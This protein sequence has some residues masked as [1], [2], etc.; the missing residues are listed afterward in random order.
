MND[1]FCLDNKR[2]F[3]TTKVI[4]S[5]RSTKI[6]TLKV[7]FFLKSTDFCHTVHLNLL[8]NMKYL[9]LWNFLISSCSA[10]CA[11]NLLV[12]FDRQQRFEPTGEIIMQFG[13][14]VPSVFQDVN[15]YYQ[16]FELTTNSTQSQYKY[17]KQMMK[18]SCKEPV[19]PITI[20]SPTIYVDFTQNYLYHTYESI[21]DFNGVG[22]DTL[23]ILQDWRMEEGEKIIQGYACKKA[24][25][26]HHEGNEITAWFAPKIPI[27]HG[28]DTLNG[29]PGLI[30]GVESRNYR[31]MAR[32]VQ[33]IPTPIVIQMPI[34]ET[35]L[36]RA[37]FF[38]SSTAQILKMTGKKKR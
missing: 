37:T 31:I 9:I 23:R 6:Y 11:Q 12:E 2:T 13:A 25:R 35:Y 5:I 29:L 27:G 3:Q 14:N 38:E 16:R 22:R 21:K 26:T 28:P 32:K 8:F 30:L 20:S 1:F 19:R 33:E 18:D 24:V 34:A 36:N 17:V 4:K 10:L 15:N 7:A